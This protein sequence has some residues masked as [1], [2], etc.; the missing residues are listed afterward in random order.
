MNRHR[1]LLLLVSFLFI[2]NINAGKDP[3]EPLTPG[4]PQTVRLDPEERRTKIENQNPSGAHPTYAPRQQRLSRKERAHKINAMLAVLKAG[5][6]SPS[7][8]R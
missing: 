7:P 4:A 1:T 2:I 3:K 6:R 8:R 5:S